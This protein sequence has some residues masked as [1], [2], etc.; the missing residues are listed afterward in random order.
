MVDIDGCDGGSSAGRSEGWSGWC[1][2]APV[3]DFALDALL[4]DFA[5][6]DL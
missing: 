3:F 2:S 1:F 6:A 5:V 4:L